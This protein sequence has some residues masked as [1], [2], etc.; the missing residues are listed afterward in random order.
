MRRILPLA[1]L[2][3]VL[4]AA[5]DQPANLVPLPEPP[6]M[7]AGGVA[8]ENV[9][10]QVTITKRGE[11]KVE[12]YRVNNKLYMIRVTPGGGGPSYYLVDL[13]GDGSWERRD[14]LD[15]GLRVPMW[16]IHTF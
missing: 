12:E 14:S 10:P 4:P 15:S 16:V 11:D 5:A 13:R 6:P 9:E 1:A 3:A 2:L 8:D 7:P